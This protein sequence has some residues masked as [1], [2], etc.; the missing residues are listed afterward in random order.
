[1]V[2]HRRWKLSSGRSVFEKN[3]PQPMT[4]YEREQY[5]I[6]QQ[7]RHELIDKIINKMKLNIDKIFN[8]KTSN[9]IHPD[10]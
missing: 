4:H 5:Y 6:R 9:K 7:Q 8:K 2:H 1:M 10:L 3:Y